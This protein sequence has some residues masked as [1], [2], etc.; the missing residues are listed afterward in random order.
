MAWLRISRLRHPTLR[1][2]TLVFVAAVCLALAGLS[3]LRIL[4]ARQADLR[5]ARSETADL[6]RSLAQQADDT[7]GAAD[8]VLLGF[9]E[10]IEDGPESR[11]PR[12]LRSFMATQDAALPA[13]HGFYFFDEHGNLA[14]DSQ[15]AEPAA[16]NYMDR[17]YF[18]W[19]LAHAEREA[20]VSGPFRSK[21]DGTR[22]MV[23][24]RRVEHPGG[25]FAGIVLATIQ[26]KFF[27]RFYDTFGLGPESVVA[28][29]GLDGAILARRPPDPSPEGSNL[30]SLPVFRTY[31]P[32]GRS[33]TFAAAGGL[34]GKPR[35]GSFHQLDRYPMLVI[36]SRLESEVLAEW[37]VEMAGQVA[38]AGVLILVVALLGSL[39]AA[40]ASERQRTEARYRLL[41]DH[42]SDAIV[43]TGLDGVRDYVSPA[44][45]AMT[46][47]RE[48]EVVG[49][50]S[51]DIVH[52]EDRSVL[53]DALGKLER[54]QE[55]A[56]AEFRYRRRDGSQFWAEGRFK[57]ARGAEGRCLQVVGNIRDVTDRKH[58]EQQLLDAI[59]RLRALSATDGLTGLANRRHFDEVIRREWGRA[60]RERQPMTLLL[61]DAD[62]FKAYNDRLGHPA[63]DA[64]LRSIAEACQGN[65]R[66]PTDVAARYGGEEF[67]VILPG[68]DG[69]GAGL[70]AEQI[71]ASLHAL[72]IPHPGTAWGTVSVSIGAASFEPGAPG[73][74][75]SAEDLLR[76]ADQALY[77]A[78]RTG[79]NRVC[80]SPNWAVSA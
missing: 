32:L 10:R 37:R 25:G 7:L 15:S 36:V 23:L 12:R 52:P 41:A 8:A 79:R 27:Q 2:A 77:T 45:A 50:R 6:A 33:G 58:L 21:L 57:L 30:S 1:F 9:R 47:W 43:C 11:L 18:Q 5:N 26:V 51:T 48:D 46:G 29:A 72:G 78:K 54:G 70:V 42:S 31:L 67:A 75:A 40:Q 13:A 74:P 28:L 61:M 38:G 63:G 44:F 73:S 14:L 20:H 3:G 76:R 19:H 60:V 65:I 80:S 39:L 62:C 59:T 17:P 16:L 49:R 69:V 34:D 56:I 24:S 55:R 22:I 35:V 71:R 53:A 64:V 66:R 4:E 68:T